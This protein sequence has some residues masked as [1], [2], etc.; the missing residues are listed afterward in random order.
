[1]TQ[2]EVPSTSVSYVLPHGNQK[3]QQFLTNSSSSSEEEK[4]S[5]AN[6]SQ[7]GSDTN[8]EAF[9]SSSSCGEDPED[10]VNELLGAE[11]G[12]KMKRPGF[13]AGN[14]SLYSLVIP[15]DYEKLKNDQ[16]DD[17]CRMELGGILVYDSYARMVG[18]PKLQAYYEENP[19]KKLDP[20][21]L[22]SKEE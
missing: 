7:D 16:Q 12:L 10:E 6:D 1:V 5:E 18:C 22:F 20:Y 14:Q 11:N 3:K 19:P 21:L 13:G 9:E 8:E 4:D 15:N 17:L 2:I